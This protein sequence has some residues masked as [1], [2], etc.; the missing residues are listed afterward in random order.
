MTGLEDATVTGRTFLA[1]FLAA[2]TWQALAG[3]VAARRVTAGRRNGVRC[4]LLNP[5]PRADTRAVP[6]SSRPGGTDNT[7]SRYYRPGGHHQDSRPGAAGRD[8]A[9]SPAG[10]AVGVNR[11]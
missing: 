9:S 1:D 2:A 10:R 4:P 11:R 7:L 6:A 5:R 8:V 3:P